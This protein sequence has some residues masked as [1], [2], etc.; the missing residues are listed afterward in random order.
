MSETDALFVPT[1]AR[2]V[3]YYMEEE[4]RWP[5]PHPSGRPGEWLDSGDKAAQSALTGLPLFSLTGLLGELGERI[6]VA[7]IAPPSGAE[8]RL[9]GVVEVDSAR[10]S[11]E[12]AWNVQAAARFALDCAE[13]VLVDP[14]R[15]WLPSGATLGEVLRAARSWLESSDG[16]TGLLGRISRIATARRLRKRGDD[17]GDLAFSITLEDEA[18]DV[19]ALD[20]PDWEAL[21]AARDAVLS[22]VEALRHEAVPQLL[23]SENVRYEEDS[24]ALQPPPE[25]VDTPWGSFIGGRRAG[26]VP[27]W[28]AARDAA[29]RARDAAADANGAAAGAGELAWQL[30]RL[31]AALGVPVD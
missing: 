15:L 30:E 2:G 11:A 8:A 23:E 1:D 4:F 26:I 25:P 31:R 5:L 12:T 18:A 6:F 13:H 22:A 16:D 10:L 29:S 9:P 19:D 7:E 27:A 20:D 28:V 24:G 3:E 14:G 17:I 21:A